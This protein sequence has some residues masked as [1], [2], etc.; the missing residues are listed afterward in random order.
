M[1]TQ[2]IVRQFRLSNWGEAV[3]ERVA[4][5]QTVRAFCAENGISSATYY[6]RQKKVREA[7]YGELIK[8][9]SHE[10]RLVPTGWTQVEESK[11]VSVTESTLSIKIGEGECHIIVNADTDADLLAKVCRVLKTLC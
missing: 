6:Y 2:K 11:P 9:E 1:N 8:V 7:A 3:K 4:S 5:G 10:E